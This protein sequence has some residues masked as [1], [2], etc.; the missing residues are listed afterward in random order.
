M[1]IQAKK[2]RAQEGKWE[3][4]YDNGRQHSGLDVVEWAKR[5][6]ELGAGE[7]LLTSVDCEGL[8]RGMDL[9][10]IR[11]VTEAVDVPVICGGGVGCA[12]DVVD[13]ANAGAS[14]VATAALLHYKKATVPQ[15]K[16]DIR[17]A[18]VE[19]RV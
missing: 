19:V 3:A 17:A 18:G 6:V 7:I 11:A 16:A 2:S 12:R 14:A 1:S 4:Y 10:L 5:G 15:L 8:Q 9:E 13:A